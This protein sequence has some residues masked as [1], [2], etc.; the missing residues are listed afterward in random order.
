MLA[1]HDAG[2]IIGDNALFLEPT[3]TVE[4]IDLGE[5]WTN[6]TGLP[7]VYA[8]WA[9]REKALHAADVEELRRARDHGVCRPEDI[10]RRYFNDASGRQRVGTT[11]LRDNIKYHL[12]PDEQAGLELFFQYAVEQGVFDAV[13]PLR[14]Y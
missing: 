11:Y 2:L 1:R 8:F 3:E 7:F 4:K 12:G 14:F 10:S 6:T 13:R 9:G 5:V